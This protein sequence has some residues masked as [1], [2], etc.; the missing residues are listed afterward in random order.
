MLVTNYQ[1]KAQETAAQATYDHRIIAVLPFKTRTAYFKPQSKD[2][3]QALQEREAA[4]GLQL[5]E[6]LYNAMTQDEEKLLVDVQDWQLTDSL[7]KAARVDFRNVN[8][9]DAQSLCRL[10]KVDAVLT[11]EL[12]ELRVSRTYTTSTLIFAASKTKRMIIELYDGKTGDH[13]WNFEKELDVAGI[14]DTE[15]HNQ[16][17]EK[18]LLKA[19]IRKF[20]Y[21]R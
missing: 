18:R 17:L 4:E 14:F 16:Y 15:K 8:N 5:Q 19:F 2:A 9:L 20:P 6:A 10:L 13:I 1:A 3:V 7:L 11:G 12:A 21:T